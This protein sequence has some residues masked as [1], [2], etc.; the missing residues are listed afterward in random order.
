MITVT[1]SSLHGIPYLEVVE[2]ERT[3]ENLPVVVF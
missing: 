2:K 1:N 3:L